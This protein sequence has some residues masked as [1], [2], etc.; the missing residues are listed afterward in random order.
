VSTVYIAPVS[1]GLGDLVVSLPAVQGL[2]ARGEATWLVAR[3][4]VQAALA[5]RIE[6]LTG[7]VDADT[8]DAAAVGGMD[9][10]ARYLDLRDHPLQRDHWWGSAPFEQAYPG[11]RINDIVGRMCADFGIEADLTH[12][13]PLV[14]LP[15]PELASSVVFVMETDGPAKR[16]P[17]ERWHALAGALGE[18]GLAVGV[19][20]HDESGGVGGIAPVAAPTPGDLVDVLSSARA[21]VGVDSGPTHVAVQQGTP[22]VT[23]CR[24]AN[25]YLRPWAHTRAVVGRPCDPTCV[26]AEEDYAYH[27]RVDLRGF[28]WEPRRCPVDGRCLA[29]VQPDAVLRALEELV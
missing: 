24:P 16:W 2:I 10:D 4:P 15:R 9:G 28:E 11:F 25:V 27:D 18:R 3:S 8:V 26:A 7:C 1:F 17:E 5:A 19:L 29:E 13:V 20:A 12:P 14:S 6:G 23:I 22:T 21:V